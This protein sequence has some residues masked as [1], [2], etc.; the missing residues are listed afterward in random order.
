MKFNWHSFENTAGLVFWSRGGGGSVLFHCAEEAIWIYFGTYYQDS[1]GVK[2]GALMLII[3]LLLYKKAKC[4][5]NNMKG[6]S[7]AEKPKPRSRE[8]MCGKADA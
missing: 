6:C 7:V 1:R 5:S 3:I 4:T 2:Q 8:Q